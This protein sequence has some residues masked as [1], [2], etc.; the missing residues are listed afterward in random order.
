MAR[1]KVSVELELDVAKADAGARGLAASMRSVKEEV[2]GLDKATMEAEHGVKALGDKSAH[3]AAD[4]TVLKAEIKRVEAELRDLARQYEKTG[5]AA[6]LSAFKQKNADLNR[7]QSVQRTVTKLES[8]TTLDKGPERSFENLRTKIREVENEVK[9]LANDYVRTGE[10]AVATSLRQRNSVLNDLRALE[11]EAKNVTEA[12]GDATGLVSSGAQGLLKTGPMLVAIIGAGVKA[13][14]VLAPMIGAVIGGAVTGAVGLGG[15]V[16]G[17]AAAKDDPRVKS[18]AANLAQ[19]FSA[20]FKLAGKPMVDPLLESLD[21]LS[22]DLTSLPLNETFKIAAPYVTQIARGI[23]GLARDFMPGFNKALENAAPVI[24]EIGRDLP[25]V[26]KALGDMLNEISNGQGNVQG[27]SDLFGI[28]DT[29]LVHL[30]HGIKVASDLWDSWISNFMAFGGLGVLWKLL[31]P[32][33]GLVAEIQQIGAQAPKMGA[34]WSESVG[35][36]V[37][38]TQGLA[39]AIKDA[40]NKLTDFINTELG[41]DNIDIQIARGWRDIAALIK[42]NGRSLDIAKA[43]GD[44][45]RQVILDQV[46]AFEHLREK[47]IDQT[48]DIYAANKAYDSNLRKLEQM[49][50]HLGF[51]AKAVHAMI[52]PLFTVPKSITTTLHTNVRVTLTNPNWLLQQTVFGRDMAPHKAAGGPVLPGVPYTINERGSET[53]TFPAAGTVHPANL[54]PWSGGG[55]GGGGSAPAIYVSVHVDPISGKVRQ[56]LVRDALGRGIPQATVQVA[57]P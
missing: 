3:A 42:D 35:K 31:H 48:G 49:L 1:R 22:R 14:T 32:N 2:H 51:N 56:V 30:G 23:G 7:L 40:E 10:V 54:V 50:I 55:S 19:E 47:T 36:M 18:A 52:D 37:T 15:I 12:A 34:A 4:M 41:I 33:E 39:D 8:A 11:R 16:G 29:T 38:D 46:A 57:Y 21:I 24:Q 43:K 20:H 45:N 25:G 53:V 28:L 6:L 26:G 27:I 17:I 9:Q 13:A 5:D 44:N